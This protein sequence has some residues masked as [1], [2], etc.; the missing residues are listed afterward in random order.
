MVHKR[1]HELI[2]TKCAGL[3]KQE[4]QDEVH[5]LH[6]VIGNDEMLDNHVSMMGRELIQNASQ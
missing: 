2:I 4:A 3:K 1:C 6:G 5:I